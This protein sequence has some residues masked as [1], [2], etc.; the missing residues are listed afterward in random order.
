MERLKNLFK[1]K[2]N[3]LKS[4]FT[5]FIIFVLSALTM[6]ITFTFASPIWNLSMPI[7]NS[8]FNSFLLLVMNFIPIFL[9]MLIIYLLTNRL[10]LSFVIP[11]ALMTILGIINKFK[12]T[13]R[14]DPFTFIDITL[15]KESLEMKDS[16]DI[17]LNAN[18]VIL[19]IGLLV[20]T[21]LLK[22][23][24]DYKMDSN[25][26][27]IYSLITVAILTSFIFIKP[28]YSTS[29]YDKVGE[30]SLI[31]IWSDSQ[32]F[33]SKG[34]IYPFIYSIKQANDT[35]P[36][37]YNKD[38]AI[39]EL[40]KF[41]YYNIPTDEKVNVIAVMLESFNDFSKF[42]T[43]DFGVDI[44]ENFH[45]LQKESYHGNIITNIFAGDTIKTERSFITG[46][47]D[48]PKYASTTNSYAWYFKE[49]GYRTKAMHPLYGWFYN[50]RNGNK[51][52]GFDGFDY[53][54]NK[55]EAISEDFFMDMQ[56][57]DF[58]IDDYKASKKDKIPYFNFSVTYQN[59]GPYSDEISPETEYLVKEPSY[60][61]GN[62][63]IINNFFFGI[64][65]TDNAVAKLIDFYRQEEEPTVIILFG[66]HNPGLGVDLAGYDMLGVNMD[67]GTE[68][69]FLNYY[70]TPYI[71][72]GN[73]AA[74]QS[75]DRDFLG[76]GEDI[77]PNFLMGE[78][79]QYLGWKGNEYLQY[80]NELK[81]S[82][83]VLN[84]LYF[85]ENGTY[86]DELSPK[87][88]EIYKNYINVEYYYSHNFK[89]KMRTDN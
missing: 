34:F 11:S 25:K 41:D 30:K 87:N 47:H 1:I 31:N 53:Y 71:V 19:F 37:D 29:I 85:K 40:K 63:N 82:I 21:I 26:F 67:L 76:K 23:L 9:A 57:F 15:V 84:K 27:R 18:M 74:K 5:L 33:Q 69:G 12:L 83:P 77:S 70:E 39:N 17:N 78:V 61:I 58:I 54:E 68:E 72:W 44:Y 42:G 79:F 6:I 86:T 49:Q 81:D 59:H 35:K 55:Y 3:Y 7:F 13:Y 52:L 10:W 64:N 50:R 20:I 56:F 32:Q 48:H 89:S 45:E 28:Y 38:S 62:Y 36:Q 43:I 75:L 80:T 2:N 16:Y 8:Y 4:L 73:E 51:F 14:D 88:E 65:E 46:F 66:D 22:I 60:D 24:F